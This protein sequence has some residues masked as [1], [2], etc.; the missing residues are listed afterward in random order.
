[1]EEKIKELEAKVKELEEK[2]NTNTATIATMTYTMGLMVEAIE[3]NTKLISQ[4]TT[5]TENLV[6]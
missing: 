6:Y 4:L 2:N 1:M 3:N 5:I